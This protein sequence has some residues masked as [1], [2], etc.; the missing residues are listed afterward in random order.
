MT[1]SYLVTEDDNKRLNSHKEIFEW[2]IEVFDHAIRGKR[3]RGHGVSVIEVI[4][5]E[6]V[7]L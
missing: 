6:Y 7:I 4:K 1:Q 5:V 3:W 2:L